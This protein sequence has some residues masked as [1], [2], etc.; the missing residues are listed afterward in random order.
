MRQSGHYLDSKSLT[1][2][3]LQELLSNR[4]KSLD[5][6]QAKIDVE[7]FVQDTRSLE[8]W[9]KDFFQAICAK[10]TAGLT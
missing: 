1:L 4:I 5:I 6:E 8:I 3:K 10:L 2:P 7:R 9:S